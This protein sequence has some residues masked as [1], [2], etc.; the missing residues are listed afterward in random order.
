MRREEA[1]KLLELNSDASEDDIKK[2]FKQLAKK[3]HPDVNKDPDASEKFKKI[4]E[5]YSR[6]QNKDD[7]PSPVRNWGGVG[8]NPIDFIN[9]N[10]SRSRNI[11]SEDIYKTADLSFKESVLGCEKN[12]SYIRNIKCDSCNG[13][14]EI[15][16]NNGCKSCNGLGRIMRQQGNMVMT[17]ICHSCR[18]NMKTSSCNKC[19]SSGVINSNISISV[20]VPPGVKNKNTLRING[21]G[22]YSGSGFIG[23]DEYTCLY[24]NCNVERDSDLS[25]LG[26]D[27]VLNIN[28]SLIEALKGCNKLVKTIDGDKEIAIPAM[29]KNKDEIIRKQ[30]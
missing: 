24:V 12:I 8:F 23:N 4:N 30:K 20:K 6:L 25:L 11:E 5:A 2:R 29:T 7:D 10:F 28:L 18:G 19:H 1:F 9:G 26:N 16:E 21:A 17:S 15:I 3:Y 27:V 22:N 14:G 13:S